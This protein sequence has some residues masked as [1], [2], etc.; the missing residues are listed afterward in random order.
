MC[1]IQCLLST[2]RYAPDSR[3]DGTSNNH[4]NTFHYLL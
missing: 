2:F 3:K 4:E 1:E